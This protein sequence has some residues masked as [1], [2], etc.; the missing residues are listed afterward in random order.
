M[1]YIFSIAS[2]SAFFF[3]ALLLGKKPKTLH[4]RILV[5]WL[6]YLGLFTGLYLFSSLEFFDRIKQFPAFIVSLF[7]LLG[8]FL[9]L[10]TSALT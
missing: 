5:Y 6:V 2:F 10:Y 9:Y 4:D 3:V 7:L 1:N 8:P